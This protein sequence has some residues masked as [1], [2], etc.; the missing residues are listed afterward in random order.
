MTDYE[1]IT[2][3]ELLRLLGDQNAFGPT[4][5]LA[6]YYRSTDKQEPDTLRI[7]RTALVHKLG[8]L[9]F[10]EPEF[11]Q[12]AVEVETRLDGALPEVPFDGEQLSGAVQYRFQR[13]SGHAPGGQA[14]G[15]HWSCR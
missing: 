5:C 15:G 1:T 14:A 11:E 13:H 7:R 4:Y 6:R 3:E 12:K 2:D 10:V 9:R 8:L